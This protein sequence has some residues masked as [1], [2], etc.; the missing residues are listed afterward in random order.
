MYHSIVISQIF[1]H[2][3][4]ILIYLQRTGYLK[5]SIQYEVQIEMKEEAINLA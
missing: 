4:L 1:S 2:I 3:S 5:P